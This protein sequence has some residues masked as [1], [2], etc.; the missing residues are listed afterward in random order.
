MCSLQILLHHGGYHKFWYI[1]VEICFRWELLYA[2]FAWPSKYFSFSVTHTRNAHFFTD[3]LQI[4]TLP[5]QRINTAHILLLSSNYEKLSNMFCFYLFIY[6]FILLSRLA[7]DW[8]FTGIRSGAVCLCGTVEPAS[9]VQSDALLA[10]E[11]KWFPVSESNAVK[12]K[13][14]KQK[15][16]SRATCKR[17]RLI[18][19]DATCLETETWGTHI[20]T[21]TLSHPLILILIH[22]LCGALKGFSGA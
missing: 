21:N 18:E 2:Q 1:M 15:R 8:D 6:L 17:T 20:H 5:H 7:F 9:I 4:M 22:R 11:V 16:C 10:G 13:T 12:K 14:K 19:R 3:H